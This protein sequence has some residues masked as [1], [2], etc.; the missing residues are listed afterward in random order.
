MTSIIFDPGFHNGAEKV[1]EHAARAQDLQFHQF[2]LSVE[3]DDYRPV[4]F[5]PHN[6]TFSN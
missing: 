2:A 5:R 3:A 6:P 1:A 4:L